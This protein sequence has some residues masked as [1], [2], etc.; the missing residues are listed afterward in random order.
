MPENH[1]KPERQ[2][3]SLRTG[4]PIPRLPSVERSLAEHPDADEIVKRYN[5]SVTRLDMGQGVVGVSV[6]F[7]E[8]IDE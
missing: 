5:G 1:D 2:F 6:E 8:T 3:R 7:P 4:E